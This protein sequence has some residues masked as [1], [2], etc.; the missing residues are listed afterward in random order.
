M[1]GGA[2]RG[3][4]QSRNLNDRLA[5]IRLDGQVQGAAQTLPRRGRSIY[6]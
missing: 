3:A 4:W 5:R 2:G 6:G 1:S